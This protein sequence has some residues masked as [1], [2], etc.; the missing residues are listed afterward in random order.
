LIRSARGLRREAAERPP[1]ESRRFARTRASRLRP[2]AP[3]A[4]RIA[5]RSPSLTPRLLSAFATSADFVGEHL[6]G[7]HARVARLA[8]P[9]QRGLVAALSVEMAVEAVVRGIDR[10]ADKPFRIRE[11]STRGLLP[12][13]LN[14][15]QVARAFG[16]ETRRDRC[17]R[18]CRVRCTRRNFDPRS[19][20]ELG[21]GGNLRDSGQ[22]RI[23][24]SRFRSKAIGLHLSLELDYYTRP[25][26]LR[27]FSGSG[28][29]CGVAVFALV[30]ID[31][32]QAL[33]Q[34][35]FRRSPN[36]RRRARPRAPP[37]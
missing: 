9:N 7:Q 31:S 1:N 17:R 25:R 24:M 22:G 27:A 16:P 2:P 26:E 14:T 6:V 30:R 36:A 35:V 4:C 13:G 33:E 21:G 28:T 15:M 11:N 19:L 12:N 32:A 37:I 10:T 20:T 5:T 29:E 18:A 34:L 3:A 23:D 8:L